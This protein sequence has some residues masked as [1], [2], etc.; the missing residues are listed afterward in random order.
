MLPDVD[1][2]DGDQ[3]QER[4]LVCSGSD[5]QTLGG[6]VQSLCTKTT[7]IAR[8]LRQISTRDQAHKP[9]PTRTLNSGGGGVEFLLESIERTEVLG[10]GLAER[11]I[12][13]GTTGTTLGTRLGQILPEQ[14]MV[15]MT[16]NNERGSGTQVHEMEPDKA[17]GASRG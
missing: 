9:A 16:C 17:S 10:D 1:T 4:V 13:Q 6:G 7:V 12:V 3:V 11:T 14:G 5:L 8:T 15:D 2:D